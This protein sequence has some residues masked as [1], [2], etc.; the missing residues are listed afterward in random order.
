VAAINPTIK[1]TTRRTDVFGELTMCV[2]IYEKYWKAQDRQF[3]EYGALRAKNLAEEIVIG[4][5]DQTDLLGFD[6]ELAG[7][8]L[9]HFSALIQDGLA[10]S[11]H[12]EFARNTIALCCRKMSWDMES[13]ENSHWGYDATMLIARALTAFS[14]Y[15]QGRLGEMPPEQAEAA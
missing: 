11:H 10:E 15:L 14:G 3:H 6:H 4:W 5:T 13:E 2:Y 1:V 7:H 9:A 8:A 12:D